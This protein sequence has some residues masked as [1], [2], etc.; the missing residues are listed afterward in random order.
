MT[1]FPHQPEKVVLT[2][3]GDPIDVR[4]YM[5]EIARFIESRSYDNVM[6]KDNVMTIY[7]GA[8]ND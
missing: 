7:P 3:A 2:F 5:V 1:D 4:K 8:V 6:T